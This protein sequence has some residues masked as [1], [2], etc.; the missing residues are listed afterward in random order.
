MNRFDDTS[1]TPNIK[2]NDKP[3]E[4]TNKIILKIF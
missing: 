1:L 2:Y 3:T 4:L